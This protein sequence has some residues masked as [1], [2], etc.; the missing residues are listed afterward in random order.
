MDMQPIFSAVY[1]ASKCQEN[2]FLLVNF[3]LCRN[4]GQYFH[5]SYNLNNLIKCNKTRHSVS[6][7]AKKH[8]FNIDK[9]P[10][11]QYV[12]VLHRK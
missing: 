9:A 3:G 8:N 5:T 4:Q 6:S 2:M 1:T 11:I 12:Y 7:K 10:V